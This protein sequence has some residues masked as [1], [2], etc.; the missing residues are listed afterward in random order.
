MSERENSSRQS[1]GVLLEELCQFSGSKSLS[2]DG[3]RGIIERHGVAPKNNDNID[4]EFFRQ[5]CDNERLTEGIIR[6]L[7]EYF[8]NAVRHADEE[9]QLPLHLKLYRNKNVT[10]G[11]M[12]LLVDAFPESVS[13]ENNHGL[14]PLHLLCRS[15]KNRDEEI[16]VKVLKLL[17]ER[18]PESVR[19]VTR[20]GN[21]PLYLAAAHQ[22]P[23][24]CR[25]LIEAYPGSERMA[26]D[27]GRLPFHAACVC[28]TV[29]TAKYLY[30]LYPES[31][32]VAS[33]N[34]WYPIHHVIRVK[35]DDH[36][37][38]EMVQFLLDCNPDVVLQKFRGKFPFYWVCVWATDANTQRLNVYLNV[39]QLLYDA[40]PEAM[41]E[42]TSNV[43]IFCEEVQTFI[44]AQNIYARQARDH[45]LMQSPDENGQLP[46]HKAL[47]D[48]VNLGSIKLL[49]KGN[50]SAI[51]CADNI[52]MI[53]LHI[54]CQ[55]HKTPAVVEYL[56]GL[57]KITL[58]TS[59]MEGNTTLHYACRGANHAII[60]LLFDKYGSMSVSKRNTHKQLPI[61]LLFA[62]E[63]VRDKESVEYIESIYRLI[64]ANPET[65]INFII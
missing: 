32:N 33:N 38:S 8:P 26:D 7:L 18:C 6:C 45:H 57:N 40:H 9:G 12:Q 10:P 54:A 3:L 14:M 65:I 13:H 48:N 25:L 29:A 28:N 2:E 56:I 5:S 39:L 20:N 16:K 15:N 61:D 34:G 53:P 35:K 4:Y 19:H 50:P 27:Y 58:T 30:E 24:F 52:G 31:I 37:S 46:L 59:D 62:S 23:E 41:D 64:R 60:A 49:V 42:V 55:H 36:E 22:S 51:S 63:A 47:R 1:A 11:M 21:L 43:D 44:N 17:I